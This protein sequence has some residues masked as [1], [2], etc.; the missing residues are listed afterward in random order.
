M[1]LNYKDGVPTDEEF[2]DVII[3]DNVYDYSGQTEIMDEIV[4]DDYGE[5]NNE[6]EEYDNEDVDYSD[7]D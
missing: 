7:G 1:A 4:K 3:D 5:V 6:E 2:T